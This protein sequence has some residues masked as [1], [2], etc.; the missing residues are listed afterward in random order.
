MVTRFVKAARR[1]DR[2][3]A[4]KAVRPSRQIEAW[5]KAELLAQVKQYRRTVEAQVLPLLEKTLAEHLGTND[6][7][8][9]ERLDALLTRLGFT[10]QKQAIKR[11][12]KVVETLLGRSDRQ[13]VERLSTI[14]S[15]SFA[16]DLA[17][18]LRRSPQLETVINAAHVNN[19]NLIKSLP[20]QYLERVRAA[21]M[22]AVTGGVRY[23]SVRD[24]ILKL[25]LV[26]E[27]R[28]KLIA[29]DQVSKLNSAIN[30][31]R[32]QDLGITQYRWST[33]HDERVRPTHRLND[34]KIFEW[35]EAPEVTG[36]PGDDY[37]CRC[38]AIP[39]INLLE[40]E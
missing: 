23:E 10:F 31:V 29:R 33:S 21:V 39:I 14:V 9:L 35:A 1:S 37:Q 6:A 19:T 4:M 32:Q 8:F 26:T 40:D 24:D 13:V 5:Y 20:A 7:S 28:A 25:G 16:I 38:V 15:V 2:Q 30:R 22:A 11:A 34:G 12:E 3:R 18:F 36:H 27:S 17:G